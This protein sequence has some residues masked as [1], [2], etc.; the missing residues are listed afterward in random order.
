VDYVRVYILRDPA[1]LAALATAD[2]SLGQ[3][4]QGAEH[5]RNARRSFVG[6]PS[7]DNTDLDISYVR[8]SHHW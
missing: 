7:F 4:P 3:P 6:V 8:H 5:E 2:M 1:L